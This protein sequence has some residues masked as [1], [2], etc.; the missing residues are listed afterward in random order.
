MSHEAC[1]KLPTV[2]I[3]S[4]VKNVMSVVY[5]AVVADLGNAKEVSDSE[6]EF[7]LV[8]LSDSVL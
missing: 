3:A 7:Y 2:L 6:N 4:Y 5:G 8:T 1:V